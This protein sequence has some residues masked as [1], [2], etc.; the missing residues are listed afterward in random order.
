MPE[1][2]GLRRTTLSRYVP[3]TYP[4]QW[5]PE[6]LELKTWEQIEPWYQKLMDQPI[7]TAPELERW[8]IAAGELN[9]AVGQEGVER[10]IAMTCQTDDPE[11]EAA[12]LAFVRDIEPKLKPIQNAIRSRYLDCPVPSGAAARPLLRLRPRPGEP[13]RPV[14]RGEHPPRDRSWPSWSSSIRRSSAR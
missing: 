11:R 5:L 14:S 12:Y 3:E 8:V 4:H 1:S 13:P 9:A 10:Y 6:K 2:T 7:E